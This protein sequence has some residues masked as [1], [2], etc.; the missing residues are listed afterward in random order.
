MSPARWLWLMVVEGSEGCGR[1]E[2]VHAAVRPTAVRPFAAVTSADI[3]PQATVAAVFAM[4]GG[5]DGRRGT[6]A[7]FNTKNLASF[8]AWVLAKYF[9]SSLGLLLPSP[10]QQ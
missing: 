8:L 7:R 10:K 5:G 1:V 3:G 2:Y 6:G 4:E 9:H